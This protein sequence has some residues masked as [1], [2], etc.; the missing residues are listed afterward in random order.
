MAFVTISTEDSSLV[1]MAISSLCLNHG[2]SG[3]DEG[4]VLFA[5][6]ILRQW[7][8]G[9]IMMAV[10]SKHRLQEEA[11]KNIVQQALIAA[12]DAVTIDVV[13]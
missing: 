10:N 9:E 3:S 8:A 4:K 7:L 6:N 11:E 1:D 12:H 13:K 5:S 2:Y